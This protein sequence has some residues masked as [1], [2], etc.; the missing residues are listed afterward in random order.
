MMPD[1]GDTFTWN[2]QRPMPTRKLG[3][4][5]ALRGIS[6][7]TESQTHQDS[8]GEHSDKYTATVSYTIC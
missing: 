7:T 3:N 2:V 1:S 6:S 4:T 8:L 5:M